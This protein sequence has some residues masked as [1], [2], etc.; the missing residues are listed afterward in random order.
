MGYS[1]AYLSDYKR[2]ERRRITIN[3]AAEV[4]SM[5]Q[6]SIVD[7]APGAGRPAAEWA[8]QRLS[9]GNDS[10]ELWIADPEVLAADSLRLGVRYLK[11]DSTEQLVW[12]TDTLRFFFRDQKISKK[13]LEKAEKR[14]LERIARARENGNFTVDSLTGDT[15]W[16]PRPDMEYFNLRLPGSKQDVNRP[17][18]LASD[19]PWESLDSAGLHLDIKADTLWKPVAASLR[20][21]SSNLLTNRRIDLAWEPGATYR[22]TVDTLAAR[23]IYGTWNRPFCQEFTVASLEDYSNLSFTL[24]GTDSVQVVVEL[25]NTSDEP[26]ARTVKPVGS[27]V[28]VFRFLQPGQYYARLFVDANANGKWDTGSIESW[29]LP[30]DV[31]YFAKKLNLKKNWDV[32]QTWLLNELPVDLQKPYAIKKNRPKLQR[33]EQ[34]PQEDEEESWEDRRDEMID[35][36]TPRRNHGSGSRPGG[37]RPSNVG[38]TP[39]RR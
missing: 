18:L 5:P 15:V 36:F 26:V 4:D 31:Y 24:P 6:V 34:A 25:L 35:P 12:T 11:T 39:S 22:L 9:A 10:L 14:E 13:D 17:L 3:F 2:P 38:N 19:T 32:E 28:A 7:G 37:L 8:L 30:E 16:P 20:P 29:T 21:D 27:E 1:P 33:G 23:S